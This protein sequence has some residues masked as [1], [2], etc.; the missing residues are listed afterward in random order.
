MNIFLRLITLVTLSVGASVGMSVGML[1]GMLV[2]MSVG[3]STGAL[4]QTG[5][6]ATDY[7]LQVNVND[8]A[9]RWQAV[10]PASR[11]GDTLRVPAGSERVVVT[12]AGGQLEL[13]LTDIDHWDYAHVL[14]TRWQQTAANTYTVH[15][16]VRH[17]DNG[18]DNYANVF[19]V[20][21]ANDNSH[22]SNG[23]RELLHPH[24]N[25]QPFTRS[26]RGVQARGQVRIEAADNVDGWGGSTIELTLAELSFPVAIRWQLELTDP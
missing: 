26:Q 25:E 21:A 15:A 7:R 1:V 13:N 11:A 17:A 3:T 18:W 8:E 19:Q 9:V 24:D 14:A 12:F 22:V 16:T 4:A 23:I 20:V 6:T 10:E 2:G 5:N